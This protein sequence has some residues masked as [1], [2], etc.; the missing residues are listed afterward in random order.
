MDFWH[1]LCKLYCI[2]VVNFTF[3]DCVSPVEIT[4]LWIPDPFQEGDKTSVLLDCVYSYE[5]EDRDSLE[6]TWYKGQG[7]KILR[8][9]SRPPPSQV[10]PSFFP[11]IYHRTANSSNWILV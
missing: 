9:D 3:M 6:I 4:A 5:E 2:I 7:K 1:I 11:W 8:D 10:T